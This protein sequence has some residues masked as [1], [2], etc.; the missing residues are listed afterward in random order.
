[1]ALKVQK[2]PH[3]CYVWQGEAHRARCWRQMVALYL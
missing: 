1:M 2:V 3:R